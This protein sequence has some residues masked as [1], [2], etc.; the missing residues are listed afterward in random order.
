MRCQAAGQCKVRQ[1]MSLTLEN[2]VDF[3]P[4]KYNSTYS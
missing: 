1:E 2:N 4:G 3:V